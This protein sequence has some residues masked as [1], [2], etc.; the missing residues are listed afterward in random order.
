MEVPD[1]PET[2]EKF[3]EF[4]GPCKE[5]SSVEFI[6]PQVARVLK[7]NE[8]VLNFIIE[9]LLSLQVGRTL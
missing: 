1:L 7:M 8:R 3:A 2:V 6:P 4:V 5:A 9:V